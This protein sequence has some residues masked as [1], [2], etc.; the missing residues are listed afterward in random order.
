MTAHSFAE[1]KSP[2]LKRDPVLLPTRSW[3]WLAQVLT[4]VRL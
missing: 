1:W 3:G 2:H 4:L